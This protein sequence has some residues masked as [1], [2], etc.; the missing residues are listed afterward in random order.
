MAKLDTFIKIAVDGKA[1]I[2][3]FGQVENAVKDV[4]KA[5][6]DL[7]DQGKRSLG[8]LDDAS[9]A[10]AGKMAALAGPA[11]IGAVVAGMFDMANTAADVAIEAGTM[12]SA[13]NLSVEEAS[14]MNA[15]FSDVGLEMNDTVDIALQ[16]GQA[17]QDD[18]ELATALG[19]EVGKAVTP[20]EAL[21]AGM[22]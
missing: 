22:G 5:T 6:E 9:G 21:R 17:V 11:A 12:A 2:A 4:D 15:A 7:G 19:L 18:A 14:R 1:A 13:L 8:G 10:L 16:I 20:V 3:E